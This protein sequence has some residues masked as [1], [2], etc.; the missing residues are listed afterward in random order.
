MLFM[1]EMATNR[2][3]FGGGG[4]VYFITVLVPQTTQCQL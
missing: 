1:H 4:V 3:L 2:N